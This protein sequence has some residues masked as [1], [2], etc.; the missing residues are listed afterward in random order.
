MKVFGQPASTDVARVLTCLFEKNLQFQLIRTD[1]FKEEHKVPEFLRLEASHFD[2]SILT[3]L[4][5][6]SVAL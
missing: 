1:M 6:V 4:Q 3:F 2:N 5:V